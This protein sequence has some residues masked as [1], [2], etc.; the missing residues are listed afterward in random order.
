MERVYLLFLVLSFCR[1]KSSGRTGCNR[2]MKLLGALLLTSVALSA[3]VI[4][5]TVV[6]SVTGSPIAGA[7][8]Q[9]ERA[10]KAPYQTTSDAQGVF[11]IDGVADGSYTALAF[12]N[13][14]LTVQDET[15]RRPFR[16]VAGLDPVHVKLSLTPRGRLSG[17]VLDADNRPV[18]GADVWLL[19][20][21]GAGQEETSDNNGGFS[22]EQPPG[23]YLLSA[24]APDKLPP[25]A[26]VADQHYAWAKTWFP[27]VT[28]AGEAQ[29]IMLRPGVELSDQDVKLRA[30]NAYSIR[31]LVRESN[32]DPAAALAV[33]LARV[34]DSEPPSIRTSVSAKDGSFT[35]DNVYDGDWRLSAARKGDGVLRAKAG[36]TITGRDASDVELRLS[37]PFNVPIE[38]F[39][40]TADSTTKIQ[41]DVVLGPEMGGGRDVPAPVSRTRNG[42]SWVEGVYPGRYL[43]NTLTPS[44]YYLASITLG[45]QEIMGRIV[46]LSADS[47]ALK[48]FYRS[49]GG[50]IRGTVEDCGNATVVVAPQDPLL[51][52]GDLLAVRYVQCTEDGHFEVR[53]LHPA[54]YY[55]FAFN[56]PVM[57]VSSFLSSL[58]A[59]I[60]KAASVEVKANESSNVDLKIT[61]NGY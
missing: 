47:P 20:A 28:N 18:A 19:Q 43:V 1:A 30:V 25:P 5:G 9:I 59:L 2:G 34:D 14:F 23:A 26:P 50:A 29:K 58:P 46:E 13:G 61:T 36:V 35:F 60:N 38:F 27:G 42:N 10:G 15:A 21:T 51:Q 49:D 44:G 53:N 37:A 48:V 8:V 11:R 17:R 12:K 24:R 57:N 33:S 55:A 3:Q 45:D 6:D 41:G 39:L 40:A 56:P 16:V 54:T 31:G 22:F 52:R 32:G 4:E 7:S